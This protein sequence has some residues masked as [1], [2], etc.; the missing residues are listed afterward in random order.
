MDVEHAPACRLTALAWRLA[1]PTVG[2]LWWRYVGLGGQH[3]EDALGRYLSGAADWAPAEHNVLAQA[4]NEVL[5]DARCPSLAPL[6]PVS[7][8]DATSPRPLPWAIPTVRHRP[9]SPC[10]ETDDLVQRAVA[11]RV[12]ARSEVARAQR[13]LAA[14]HRRPAA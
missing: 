5:W 12:R 1:S 8:G 10:R 9:S 4:L 7:P 14:G 6:R 2:E 13:L 3:D 11:A